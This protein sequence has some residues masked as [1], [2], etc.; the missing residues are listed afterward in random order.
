MAVFFATAGEVPA[1]FGR[2]IVR[3]WTGHRR[4]A[5]TRGVVVSQLA[6]PRFLLLMFCCAH[7]L[8]T[9]IVLTSYN[10]F[11]LVIHTGRPRPRR[12]PAIK[13]TKGHR[14]SEGQ[15]GFMLSLS[16][17]KKSLSLS[18]SVVVVV[19]DDT[20]LSLLLLLLMIQKK[21]NMIDL[22]P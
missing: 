10:A 9:S 14:P 19:V 15:G 17:H 22:L 12:K 13:T 3:Q 21:E 16:S 1:G 7:T 8:V 11:G 6:M 2:P 20:N 18:S 5:G 4:A